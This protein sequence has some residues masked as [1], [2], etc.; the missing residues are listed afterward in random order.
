MLVNG[1]DILE[2]LKKDISFN[3]GSVI[4]DV[5]LIISELVSVIFNLFVYISKKYFLVVIVLVSSSTTYILFSS[6]STLLSTILKI[7]DLT[8]V[9]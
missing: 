6:S 8:L 7:F 1:N 3:N 4:I 5:I 9:L 2:K